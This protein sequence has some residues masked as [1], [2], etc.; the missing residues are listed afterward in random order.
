MGNPQGG[1]GLQVPHFFLTGRGVA[2]PL[3]GP[4]SRPLQRALACVRVRG[5]RF[6]GG[7]LELVDALQRDRVPGGWLPGADPSVAVHVPEGLAPSSRR[8]EESAEGF[9]AWGRERRRRAGHR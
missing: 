3:Q 5:P 1:T 8:P 4:G 2:L 6:L 7:S 9:E